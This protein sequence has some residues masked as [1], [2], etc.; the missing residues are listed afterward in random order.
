MSR[1]LIRGRRSLKRVLRREDGAVTVEVVLWLPI[2]VFL[3]ALMAD[4][5]LIFGTKAQILRIVQDANRATSIGR[6]RTTAETVTYIRTNLGGFAANATVTSVVTSGV[7]SS[8]VTIP[9]EDLT[10]TGFFSGMAN[11]NVTIN[12]QHR[13][14]A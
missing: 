14:E 1:F 4:A 3:L 5:S 10:A 2:L 12:A 8:T 13:L 7:V 9:S 6:F 11:F